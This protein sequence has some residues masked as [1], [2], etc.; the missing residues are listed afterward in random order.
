MFLHQGMNILNY[1][2]DG[3]MNITNPKTISNV[4]IPAFCIATM[5]T[6]LKGKCIILCMLGVEVNEIV[7]IW[8]S[9]LFMLPMVHLKEEVEPAQVLLTRKF[10]T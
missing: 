7:H 10:I 9:Q 2:I 4:Q 5:P 3:S 1:S 8:N 6:K